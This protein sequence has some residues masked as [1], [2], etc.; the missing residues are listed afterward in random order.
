MLSV[1][2]HHHTVVISMICTT[3]TPFVPFYRSNL[4][5]KKKKVP[6]YKMKYKF[7]DA[8]INLFPNKYISY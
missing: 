4:K 1:D 5:K 8:L 7:L 2:F 6:E 3:N